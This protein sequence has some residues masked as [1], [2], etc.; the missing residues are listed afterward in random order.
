MT[1]SSTPAPTAPMTLDNGYG[2]WNLPFA[3]YRAG[4]AL[5]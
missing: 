4:S 5:G 2:D 3:V 1:W